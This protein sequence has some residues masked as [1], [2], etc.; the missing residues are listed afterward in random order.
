MHRYAMVP[1][2]APLYPTVFS[3]LASPL[4]AV[5]ESLYRIKQDDIEWIGSTM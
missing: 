5:K 1:G 4:H 2:A 3:L